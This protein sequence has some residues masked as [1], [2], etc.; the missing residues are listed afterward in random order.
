MKQ[1]GKSKKPFYEYTVKHTR[2]KKVTYFPYKAS[3]KT[4]TTTKKVIARNMG[5]VRKFLTGYKNPSKHGI[6]KLVKKKHKGR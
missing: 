6:V 3:K 5:E 4:V 1:I 2:P